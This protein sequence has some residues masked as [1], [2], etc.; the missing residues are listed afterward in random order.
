[1]LPPENDSNFVD[2]HAKTLVPKVSSYF[3]DTPNFFRTTV[4]KN[5]Q[6]MLSPISIALHNNIDPDDPD[7]RISVFKKALNTRP[8][9]WS[10]ISLF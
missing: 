4:L 5:F 2:Q 1:L 6:T 9:K 7:E 3:Q 10:P 8:D